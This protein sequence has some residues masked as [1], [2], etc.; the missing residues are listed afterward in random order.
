MKIV[1]HLLSAVVFLLANVAS[2]QEDEEVTDAFG[3]QQVNSYLDPDLWLGGVLQSQDEGRHLAAD[4]EQMGH[5]ELTQTRVRYRT[6][7]VLKV[8][9]RKSDIQ[10]AAL[11]MDNGYSFQ[12]PFFVFENGTSKQKGIWYEQLTYANKQQ[13]MGSGLVTL[14]F[15]LNT[16]LAMSVVAG[17]KQLAILGGSGNLFGACP[18][19]YGLV[20]GDGI[21]IVQFEFTVCDACAPVEEE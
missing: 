6:C 16:S 2:A 11:T 9:I 5:R 10:R 7:E 21:D 20:T 18:S 8:F 4:S 15:N 17:Q 1:R 3:S 12:I 13:N 19:G 14:K